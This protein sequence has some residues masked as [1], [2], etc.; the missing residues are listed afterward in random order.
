MPTAKEYFDALG[1]VEKQEELPKL[2]E[3]MDLLS[4]NYS[5]NPA[6]IA[7]I[8]QKYLQKKMELEK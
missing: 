6:Y 5:D 2:K 7:L 1:N 3:R 8:E 4:L